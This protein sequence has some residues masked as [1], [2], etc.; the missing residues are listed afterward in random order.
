MARETFEAQA[1]AIRHVLRR[2]RLSTSERESLMLSAQTLDALALL[3]RKCLE[4]PG[5]VPESE[6]SDGLSKE[7]IDLLYLPTDE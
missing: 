2:N 1:A 4:G 5:A 6:F 3:R 7:I